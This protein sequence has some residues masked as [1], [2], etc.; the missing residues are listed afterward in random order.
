MAKTDDR[1]T[2]VLEEGDIFFLYRP[3][4]GEDDPTG[5]DDVQRFHIVLRPHGGGRTRLLTVGRK[6]LPDVEDHERN[7][8]FVDVVTDSAENLEVGLREETYQTKTRGEQRRPA[9]RPAGE[10]VYAISLEEGQ[11]H[12]SYALE[13]PKRPGEVQK[14]L[15]IRPEASYVLSI[16][17]PEK[18][19]PKGAGLSPGQKVDYPRKLQQEFRGRR[20]AGEDARLL[21][22][23]GAE[24]ILVGARI[25]P[26]AEYGI[27]L[28]TQS[29]DYDRA[30]IIRKL[31]MVK[32]R[33]PVK[34]LFEGRWA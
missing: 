31:R 7:W 20:F 14:T 29:E 5:L 12:L 9:A 13:L 10:G 19:Q 33:H 4:V 34:P 27:D 11:M 16:K 1:K 32:S 21:D 15:R 30:E 28:E 24:F 18:G 3:T 8:G 25:D 6:R 17:N 2:E 23:E 26:D 22:F